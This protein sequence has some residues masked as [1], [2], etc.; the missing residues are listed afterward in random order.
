[1]YLFQNMLF[2]VV[3]LSTLKLHILLLKVIG[4]KLS[5]LLIVSYGMI[6]YTEHSPW[7]D[8]LF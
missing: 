2:S 4:R 7:T 1:M 5:I 6:L 3:L 8:V